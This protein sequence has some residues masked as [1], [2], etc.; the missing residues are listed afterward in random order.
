MTIV[1]LTLVDTPLTEAVTVYWPVVEFAVK[2]DD[3]AT[4]LLEF[5]VSVSVACPFANVPLA[6]EVGALNVTAAPPTGFPPLSSTVAVKG[7]GK[8]VPTGTLCPDPVGCEI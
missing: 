6:P 7:L 1:K 4:P 8:A 5:V 3:V 2:V